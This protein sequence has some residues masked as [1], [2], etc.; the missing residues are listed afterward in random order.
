MWLVSTDRAELHF[1]PDPSRVPGGYAILSHTW[2]EQEQTFQET[3]ALQEHCTVTLENPRELSSAK[4]RNACL[5]AE[6]D[7]YRW[8]WID[9]CCIDKTS[10]T[11]LSEAINSMF[12][13]YA[14][15]EV[16]YAHLEDVPSGCARTLEQPG[17]AFRR[18]R[19][20]TRGWTLQELLA[21]A[22]VVFVSNEWANLGTKQDLAPLLSSI[23]GIRVSVLARR[24]TFFVASVAERM[25][26]ASRRHTRRVEDEAYCL[27]GLFGINMPTIYGEGRQAFQRLQQE[28]AR[29]SIDT[30]LFA[31]GNTY[32]AKDE[33]RSPVKLKRMWADFHGLSKE[34]RFLFAP[35]PRSF[36]GRTVYFTPS[37]SDPIQ[38]YL[39]WRWRSHVSVTCYLHHRYSH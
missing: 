19:W 27:L 22:L 36:D 33:V 30:S 34:G 15:A 3:R 10:S 35:S 7:G 2:N 1:F 20:H 25:S 12:R 32:T 5:I 6:Q 9:T 21:P 38:P 14:C 26:W 17:S 28:I 16:C 24:K 8:I 18:A 37:L 29:Q 31:W 39:P 23:T 13:W 4:I 11:E